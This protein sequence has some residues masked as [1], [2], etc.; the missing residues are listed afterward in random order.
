[1][2]DFASPTRAAQLTTPAK[3]LY[4]AFAVLNLCGL[5]SSVMLYDGI[6]GF[7]ARDTPAQLYERLLAHY[8]GP[9]Y[10]K[11]LEVT[12]A[13]LFS[14]SVLLLVAG[15]LFLLTGATLRTKL[16]L[17]G[18]GVASVVLHLAAPWILY[19]GHGRFGSGLIYPVSGTLMLLSLGV[20]TAVPA[21]T[22]WR[23]PGAA[24]Q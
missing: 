6:V 17:I 7:G 19:M 21:W 8:D 24:A 3:L 15:H 12:H 16:W 20:M 23:K 10:Q 1:M 13:H 9:V 4:S 5:L 11:L 14:T 18:V 2:R 22:M